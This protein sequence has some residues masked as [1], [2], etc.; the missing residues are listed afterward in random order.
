MVDAPERKYLALFVG[1][2]KEQLELLQ[3]ELVRLESAKEAAAVDLWASV[4]RRVHSVK[5]SAATLGLTDIVDVSHAAEALIGRLTSGKTLPQR[6]HVDALLEASDTLTR[7][8]RE[9]GKLIEPGALFVPQADLPET[10]P[11]VKKLTSLAS[12]L[13]EAALPEKKAAPEAA[14]VV[15]DPSLPRLEVVVTLSQKCAAPGAR[16]MIVQRKLK[17][18]G[19]LIEMD[20][21]PA[22]LMQTKGG[23][24]IVA[25]LASDKAADEIRAVCL[26][27][28]EVES[29]EITSEA[30][31][32]VVPPEPVR[33]APVTPPPPVRND[34][35]R[36]PEAE[37][38]ADATVRVK[39]E[40]LDQLL[41]AA[42]EVLGGISRLR[43][44]ARRL[45]E[46]TGTAFEHEIDRL[47]RQ[48]RE[49][50][51]KVVNARLVPFSL[52]T[53]RLPRAVRDL[54][55][56]LGKEVD[57]EIAGADVELD[58]AVIEALGDPLS[59]LVRNAVDHGLETK[60]LREEAGKPARGKLSLAAR[61][62]RDRVVVQLEDDG[63]GFDAQGLKDRAVAAGK[64]TAEQAA[65]MSDDEAHE[66]AFLSGVSTRAEADEIS[67]RGVGLD[68]VQR[69]IESLGGKLS[70]ASWR[71]KGTRFSLELPR[72]VSMSNLLLVQVGGELYGL[73]VPRVLLTTEYDL[74]ARG[75][76]GFE[77]RSVIV[78][79]QWVH[80]YG[81]A[82]LFGLPSLA[83]PG[84][85]PF[86]VLEVDGT[87]FAL[88][89]DRLVG[90]EEAVVKPLFP[91][92]DR[93]AGLAG[94]A[95]LGSGRPLLV[96]DPR[97]LSEMAGVRG[98]APLPPRVEAANDH[99]EH[100]A[101]HGDGRAH[102]AAGSGR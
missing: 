48:A 4:F 78:G 10:P 25:Q 97:S 16:A 54:A 42:G 82:K 49:L 20:P 86:V 90:Q 21:T 83:P 12:A 74:S 62:E 15:V 77:S 5:G 80:A 58:R 99:T 71:G 94:V 8:V 51:N 37:L 17:G 27:V 72:S 66:L 79:G 88:A 23:A 75:G 95:V 6:T 68:A 56:K 43:E 33:E 1:E 69:A 3:G 39:A 28:P 81:L 102:S 47:R 57:F 64:L 24:R 89:V 29:V 30:G 18:L 52:L 36:V 35:P 91:P 55:H 73:P 13:A 41:E 9:A 31:G 44:G 85:R 92:L 32:K 100:G 50:H 101:G 2:A 65:A 19:T 59:H 53:E 26:S 22:Q 14:K 87:T 38:R 60:A 63:R 7:L 11:V 76:E 61:R 84:P 67:G 70:V 46:N 93:V 45:P 34:Q 98:M 96:L 40:L